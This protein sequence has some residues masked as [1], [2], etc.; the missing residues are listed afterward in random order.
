MLGSNL[1]IVDVEGYLNGQP[2]GRFRKM[3]SPAVP[4]HVLPDPSYAEQEITIDPYPLLAGEPTEICVDL[5]NPT[6]YPQ[7]VV[8]HFSWANLNRLALLTR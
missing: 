2:I 4:L 5:R 3:D 1:P 7:N 6:P 8:V